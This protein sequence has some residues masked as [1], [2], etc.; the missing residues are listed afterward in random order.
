[1]WEEFMTNSFTDKLNKK[2]SVSQF[3]HDKQNKKYA[4]Q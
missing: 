3:D 4:F 1:M 2:V